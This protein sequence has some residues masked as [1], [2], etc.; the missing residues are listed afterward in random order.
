MVSALIS[1]KRVDTG[2]EA[3]SR[4]PN[5]FLVVAGD[6]PLRDSLA[7]KAA[8]VLPERYRTLSVPSSQMPD[9]YR[10]ANVFLHLSKEES[11]GNVFLE[12]MACGLPIVADDTP[13]VR[14]I[15][16]DGEFLVDTSD[17]LAIANAIENASV[18]ELRKQKERID[19]V[20]TFAWPRVAAMYSRFLQEVID[21][22]KI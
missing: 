22:T 15:L 10:S 18:A 4:I 14:W 8:R 2:I 12:A 11:F 13:H 3:V 6:G 16:G 19:Q 17:T 5:S 21:A 7:S 1:S 9:L 20:T